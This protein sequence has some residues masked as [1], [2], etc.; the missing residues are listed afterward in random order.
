MDR[1]L[2]TRIVLETL[3]ECGIHA[4]FDGDYLVVR[5]DPDGPL[6]Y[7]LWLRNG[8]DE[9]IRVATIRALCKHALDI[10]SE[11]FHKAAA[12]VEKRQQKG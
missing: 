5:R 11:M 7:K 9:T 6:V 1:D 2:S 4:S 8:K 10:P 3:L 12:K